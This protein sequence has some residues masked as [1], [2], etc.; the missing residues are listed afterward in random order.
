MLTISGF[1]IKK[2]NLTVK[3]SN[4]KEKPRLISDYE[5]FG[6][7]KFKL[8]GFEYIALYEKYLFF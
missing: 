4:S 8:K 7:L 3:Y 1:K 5:V 2:F 6:L